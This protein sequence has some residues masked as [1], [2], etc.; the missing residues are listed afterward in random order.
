MAERFAN[1][2]SVGTCDQRQ[3]SASIETM[4]EGE[5]RNLARSR[6]AVTFPSPL[7]ERDIAD[8]PNGVVNQL[9]AA[10]IAEIDMLI[11]DLQTARDHVRAEGERIERALN[12]YEKLSGAS[13][14]LAGMISAQVGNGANL[15]LPTHWA[16]LLL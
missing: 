6:K 16:T 3:A 10:P 8:R 13:L 14:E 1:L 11:S 9:L 2:L 15:S 12:D 4:V 7:A 5:I